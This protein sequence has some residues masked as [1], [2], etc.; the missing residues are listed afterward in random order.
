MRKHTRNISIL[1]Y[2]I[3][4]A[5][6]F[7][8][9]TNVFMVSVV[10]RHV[11]SGTDLSKY[12]TNA[13]VVTKVTKAIRGNIYDANGT[14]IAQDNRTYNIIC[15]LDENR[16]SVDGTI[17]YVKDK[18]ATAKALSQ[19]LKMDYDKCLSYLNTPNQYQTEL[20][21]AGRNLS[22][23]KMEE[24]K[25]LNLPGIE[26]VPSIQRVYPLGTFASNLIG[27]AQS[28]ETGSTVGKMGVELYLDSYLKGI[29]GKSTY[30]A[31]SQGHILPGMKEESISAVNGNDVYLTID[32]PIQEALEESFRLTTKQFNPRRIWGAVMDVKTGK[33]LAWGQSPSFDPNTLDIQDYNNYGAQLPYEPGST[34]KTFTWASAINEGKYDPDQEAYSGPFCYYSDANN[35]PY[36]VEKGGW[37]CINNARNKNYGNISLDKGLVYSSNSIAAVIQN[38]LITPDIYLSYLK[39]FG[40]FQPVS[41]DG[42]PEETGVLNYY[43]PGDKISLSYGQGSTVTMLQMLQAYSAIFSDGTMVRPYFVESIKDSYDPSHVLY[44]AKTKVTGNPITPESAKVIQHSLYRVFNDDDGSA[45]HYQIPECKLI[46]KTGTTQV[47][48]NGT[49]DSG[50][51]ITSLMAGLPAENPQV[52]VYYCFEA[53]YN[54]D[55]HF[56]SEPIKNLL[57][58]TAMRLGFSENGEQP[59][60]DTTSP[61]T[62]YKNYAMPQLVNHSLEYANTK[63]QELNTQI[64]VLG[65]G[66]SVISQFPTETS[67]VTTGQKVFL[68]TDTNSFVLPDMTGWTR[69]DVTAL[70]AVSEF[71]FKLSGQGKVKSQSIPAGTTVT[72]GM[73]IEV[74]FE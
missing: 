17:T 67:T 21:N 22:Q 73:Q 37:N 16:L 49:Y 47:A 52:A 8:L 14:I 12:A 41:T 2:V 23:A 58:K 54:P 7:S 35:N 3:S 11:L 32:Q 24:I 20:G 46:G 66:N 30:Q 45:R 19:V 50:Y 18:E 71:G 33:I 63:L 4:F 10:K 56:Y 28:D 57:R 43:W 51:T 60:Q 61:I 29:D 9:A 44:Q 74:E 13:S 31:D 1:I 39:K 27:F 34:M 55:T 48:I 59:V 36:R 26:F 40:F 64:Y 70:W 42:L 53:L 38:E 69:K 62:E 68:L 72:R 15:V 6:M 65:N 25:A 5:V